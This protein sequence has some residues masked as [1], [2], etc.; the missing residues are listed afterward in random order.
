MFWAFVHMFFF[1]YFKLN[2]KVIKESFSILSLRDAAFIALTIEHNLLPI[3][4]KGIKVLDV[5][6]PYLHS[7]E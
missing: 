1:I 5:N 7:Y 4:I 2:Y 6:Y 3:Q